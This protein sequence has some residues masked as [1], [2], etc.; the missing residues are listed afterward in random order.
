MFVH[1]S[2]HSLN[3]CNIKIDDIFLLLFFFNR[4]N[5]QTRETRSYKKLLQ[6]G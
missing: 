6:T 4:M 1:V 3:M 5:V 2:F